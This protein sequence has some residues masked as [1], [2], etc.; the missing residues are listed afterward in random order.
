MSLLEQNITKKRQID[1][2]TSRLKFESDGDGK[3]YK[4]EAICDNAVYARESDGHLLSVYYLVSWKSYPREKNIWE[5]AFA[6][7]HLRKLISTFHHDQ[8]DK[9]IATLPPTNSASPM[10]RSTMRPVIRPEASSTKRKRGRPT[11]TNGTS[12]RAKKSWTSSFLFRF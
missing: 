12:K 11:K 9:P 8:S 6:M 7:L 3:E 1:E 5:P 10:A 4:V 2:T